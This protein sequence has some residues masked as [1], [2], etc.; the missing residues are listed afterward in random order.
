MDEDDRTW[1]LVAFGLVAGAGLMLAGQVAGQSPASSETPL[2]LLNIT[3]GAEEDPHTVTMALQLAGH[4]LDD[5]RDVALFFNVRGARVATAAPV[6]GGRPAV[7]PP[8]L[9]GNQL[10][11][12]QAAR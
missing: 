3:S 11:T 6:G 2:L 1:I 10:D 5:G 8:R 9:H 4:A 12:R 7:A